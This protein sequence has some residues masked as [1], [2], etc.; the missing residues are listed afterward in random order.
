MW[1]KLSTSL[2]LAVF[3]ISGQAVAQ[4]TPQ[5]TPAQPSQWY[6]MPGPWHMWGDTYGWHYWSWMPPMML[7]FMFLVC[8]AVVYVL[9]GRRSH[10]GPP[11][12]M[13][14]RTWGAATHSALQILNERF[15][16][17]EIQKDEYEDRKSAIL[18]SSQQH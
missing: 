10:G 9:F 12:H 6:W 5:P 17:G 7:L 11:W 13:M 15:A 1:Q 3:V 2:I 16:R 4:Q 8:A 18:A 14:D